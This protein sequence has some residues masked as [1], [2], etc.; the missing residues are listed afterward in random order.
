MKNKLNKLILIFAGIAGLNSCSPEDSYSVD[1]QVELNNDKL[2][3]SYYPTNKKSNDNENSDD[4][5]SHFSNYQFV[6]N[7]EIITLSTILNNNSIDAGEFY[8]LYTEKTYGFTY[9]YTA[10]N[11][12]DDDCT[13]PPPTDAEIRDAMMKECED[14]YMLLEWPCMAAVE[15]AYMLR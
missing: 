1:K 4:F 8:N 14:G 3:N 9:S 5:V 2:I 15:I 11:G 6:D 10:K 13:P 12:G 7:N